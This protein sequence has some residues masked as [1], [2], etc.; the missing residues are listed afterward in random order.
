MLL[1]EFY[2]LPPFFSFKIVLS[3]FTYFLFSD[4]LYT[5]DAR[6]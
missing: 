4:G 2:E 3:I 5:S 1:S 6:A